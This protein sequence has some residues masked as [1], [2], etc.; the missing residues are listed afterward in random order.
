MVLLKYNKS[1]ILS[2]P[3]NPI[4]ITLLQIVGMHGLNGVLV[5]ALAIMQLNGEDKYLQLDC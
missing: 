2:S 1:T 3:P 4:A 5:V